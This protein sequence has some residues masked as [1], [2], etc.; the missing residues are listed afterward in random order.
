MGTQVATNVTFQKHH[1]SRDKRGYTLGRHRGFRGC[2][3]WF[4]GL[5]GAGKTS[6]SFH[7]EEWLISR[8]ISAYGLDGDNIRT[9]LNQDLGFSPKDRKE[10]IRRVAEVAKLFADSGTNA[11]CSFGS[12]FAAVRMKEN[13]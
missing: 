5:S 12:P 10:N 13:G 4:T 2:T 6:I 8:G 11:L 9:G 7:L 3:V 1:V